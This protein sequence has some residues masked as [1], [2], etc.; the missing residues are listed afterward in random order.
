[1]ARRMVE[2]VAQN[3]AQPIRRG[4][5]PHVKV[6]LVPGGRCLRQNSDPAPPV[7]QLEVKCIA[8]SAS[9]RHRFHERASFASP[10]I[11]Q[12]KR[13]G[14]RTALAAAT[15]EKKEQHAISNAVKGCAMFRAVGGG[16]TI[17]VTGRKPLQK[18][19]PA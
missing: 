17:G 19:P 8:A 2:E 12:H 13:K 3:V 1:M 11:E 7:V 9:S 5:S 14:H 6:G 10:A 4:R 16:F 18:A 15:R